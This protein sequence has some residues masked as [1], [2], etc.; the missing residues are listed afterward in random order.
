MKDSNE[1]KMTTVVGSSGLYEILIVP[2]PREY[3]WTP[4]MVLVRCLRAPM[5][6]DQLRYLYIHR[7]SRL[8]IPDVYDYDA[9][10]WDTDKTIE[11]TDI[12]DEW[13]AKGR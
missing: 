3:D 7:D 8:Y 13:V 11:F 6:P 9:D 4:L 10:F 2:D 12:Y 1:P 5:T